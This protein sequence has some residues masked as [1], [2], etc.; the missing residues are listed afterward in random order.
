MYKRPK[1]FLVVCKLQNACSPFGN[2]RQLKYCE[3]QLSKLI[4]IYQSLTLLALGGGSRSKCTK[5]G[6]S[7]GWCSK[8]VHLVYRY[9]W[10]KLIS[11][12]RNKTSFIQKNVKYIRRWKLT[13]LNFLFSV[14]LGFSTNCKKPVFCNGTFK[15]FFLTLARQ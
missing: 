5:Q 7:D 3:S 8:L 15:A 14:W 10:I 9:F 1:G 6:S 11:H 2:K 13:F 12:P 4:V